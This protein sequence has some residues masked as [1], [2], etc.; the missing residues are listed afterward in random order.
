MSLGRIASGFVMAG[1]FFLLSVSTLSAKDKTVYTYPPALPAGATIVTD[2]GPELLK[3]L[4]ELKPGVKIAKTPPT[5]D[6]MYFPG[7]DYPG[8]PWSVWGD[9]CTVGAKY[10]TAIGDH[11]AP[12]GTA[13]VFEY[14]P[15][16]RSL[17]MLVDLKTFLEASGQLPSSMNYIPAK[18]HSRIDLGSDGWLYYSGH[19]GS[20]GTT[21]DANGF[22]GDWIFRTHPETGKSEIVA[23]HPVEK[24]VIPC[25]LL[26]PERMIFYGGTAAGKNA[27]DQGIQFFAYDVRNKKLLYSG[28]DGPARY[29]FLATSTGRLY[30]APGGE[31]VS[32]PL[33]R[34]DP[35][36]SPQPEP[37]GGEIGLRSATFETPQGFVYTV[38]K[39][40]DAT[41]WSFETK[42]EKIRKLGPLAVAEQSYITSLD[43][44]PTGRYLY[45]V[46]GAHGRGAGEG[47][48]IVQYDVQT[49]TKKVIAFLHPFYQKKYGY[50]PDGTFSSALDASGE[51]LFITWNG[52]R[53]PNPQGASTWESCA[54]TVIH[55]P[56]S[57]RP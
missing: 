31:A 57:E 17:R 47:T 33:M 26:D 29:M 19:R 14:D 4:A 50:T 55:I 24:H 44:D 13:R 1:W 9:G 22:Q 8:K 15:A 52:T 46:A 40:A 42:T 2:T 10:Y 11:M 5:I 45:Y 35:A 20:P 27:K 48:P 34:F 6:F 39:D 21:T 3:P 28:P 54:L 16:K 41:L 37:V 51:T 56:A 30:Y 25:S 36:K 18:I 7:Q 49:Q 32:S 43:V 38:S 53:N 12:K 23:S